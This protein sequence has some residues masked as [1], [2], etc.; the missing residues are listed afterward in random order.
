MHCSLQVSS[1]SL[2]IS[3]AS[4]PLE[5]TFADSNGSVG[6]F[7]LAT[8]NATDLVD[9]DLQVFRDKASLTVDLR[10]QALSC[11]KAVRWGGANLEA[12]VMVT[13]IP[14]H[15]EPM[16]GQWQTVQVP[17]AE[18]PS[19][20]YVGSIPWDAIETLELIAESSGTVDWEA[21][22]RPEPPKT[23]LADRSGT[24]AGWLPWQLSRHS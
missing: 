24:C 22:S 9:P 3:L 1:F 14:A 13:D 11:L 2:S 17:L 16:L 8:V 4:G 15:Y 10:C 20:S 18:N 12:A 7:S 21:Q 6:K 19:V 5:A 23:P